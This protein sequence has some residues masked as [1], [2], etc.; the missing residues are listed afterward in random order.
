MPL[1]VFQCSRCGERIEFLKLAKDE[2]VP[3]KH[4]GCGGELV[5]QI[6]TV[7]RPQIR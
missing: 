1:L 4:D 2:P 6:S 7:G 5:Q 3:T